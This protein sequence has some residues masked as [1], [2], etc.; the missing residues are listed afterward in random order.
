MESAGKAAEAASGDA[1]AGAAPTPGTATAGKAAD[2]LSRVGE[3]NEVCFGEAV[4]KKR[5]PRQMSTAVV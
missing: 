1:S 3:S 5:R 4:E 2:V